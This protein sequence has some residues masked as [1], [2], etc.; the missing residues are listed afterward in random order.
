MTQASGRKSVFV[1]GAASGIG[2]ATALLFAQR[3]WFVGAFDVSQAGLDT[4]QRDI[5]AQ[6]GLF[7]ALDVTD[8]QAFHAAVEAFGAATGGKLD[9]LF[10]NAGIGVGGL[11][12]ELPWDDVMRIVSV[13]FLGVMIGIQA[14]MPLLKATPGALC[15]TTSSSSAIWGTGGI[16]VYSAT[17]HAVK[18]LTEA[19]SVEFKRHGLRAAD[20]QPGLIDTPILPDALRAM[21]PPDGMWRL[22]PPAEVAEA[23]WAAYGSDQLHWYVPPQL[24]DFALQVVQSPEQVREERAR[25]FGFTPQTKGPS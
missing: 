5:G 10:N 15:L 11:F 19:L 2:R 17:K 24:K 12:D 7:A 3:G 20:L 6:N 21:A 25:Q 23:V 13:N 22:V 16:A 18:G 9:L 1:T 4:L 14:A 8:R